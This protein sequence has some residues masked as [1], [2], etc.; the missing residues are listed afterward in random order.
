MLEVKLK[1]IVKE[2]RKVFNFGKIRTV[3]DWLQPL[4]AKME[5]LNLYN[6]PNMRLEE[7]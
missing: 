1:D 3:L 5:R 4:L 6:V 2:N 7:F